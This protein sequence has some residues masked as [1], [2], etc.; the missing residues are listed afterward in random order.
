MERRPPGKLDS[1][2]LREALRRRIRREDMTKRQVEERLGRKGD[3]LRQVLSGRSSLKWDHVAGILAVLGIHPVEFFE[4]IYGPPPSRAAPAAF[5]AAPYGTSG[6]LVRW[7]SLQALS[8]SSSRRASS[9]PRRPS[10][11]WRSS[12]ASRRSRRWRGLPRGVEGRGAGCGR[13]CLTWASTLR[14]RSRAAERWARILQLEERGQEVALNAESLED[15][16]R[17][18]DCADHVGHAALEGVDLREVERDDGDCERYLLLEES[19]SYAKEPDLGRLEKSKVAIDFAAKPV[20]AQE[21]ELVRA[22]A[23]VGLRIRHKA[24]S[25]LRLAKLQVAITQVVDGGPKQVDLGGVRRRSEQ[26]SGSMA[27]RGC[28]LLMYARAS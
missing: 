3:Y 24:I 26:W 12:R 14:M 7:S 25:Q 15:G 2:T 5:A 1:D 18:A 11:C 4:E 21:G 27:S 9:P 17:L 13:P 23:E 10:G 8:G 28:P 19:I 22:G 6:Q 20:D 16:D